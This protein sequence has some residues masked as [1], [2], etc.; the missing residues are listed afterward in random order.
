MSL[1]NKEQGKL[2]E[3][4]NGTLISEED[5]KL[6]TYRQQ[7]ECKLYKNA[8]QEGVGEVVEKEL[9]SGK[10]ESGKVV[11]VSDGGDDWVLRT[12]IGK[13]GDYFVC[14]AGLGEGYK[15]W[16]LCKSVPQ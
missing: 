16:L 5:Y 8:N 15:M 14:K 1:L 7:S 11:M 13:D 2:Y 3:S 9:E 4:P 10:L 6:L 12:F